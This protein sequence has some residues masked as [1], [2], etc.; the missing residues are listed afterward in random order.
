MTDLTEQRR[1]NEGND[2]SASIVVEL[3]RLDNHDERN[4]VFVNP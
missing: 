3:S 1:S 4:A 2:D